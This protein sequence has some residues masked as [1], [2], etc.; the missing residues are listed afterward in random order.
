M[1]QLL[2]LGIL[3]LAFATAPALANSFGL[4]KNNLDLAEK[5]SPSF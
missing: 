4:E 2:V 3:M 5:T 1:R